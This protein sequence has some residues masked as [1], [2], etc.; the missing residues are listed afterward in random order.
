MT[1][2]VGNQ[3]GV[4]DG[5]HPPAVNAAFHHKAQSKKNP[6]CMAGSC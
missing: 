5:H 3:G 4:F 2:M 6:G 1:L